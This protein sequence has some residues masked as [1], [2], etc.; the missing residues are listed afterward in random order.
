MTFLTLI[1]FI[2]IGTG[3]TNIVVNASILDKVREAI[4]SR[5]KFMAGLLE[6]MLCTGFWVGVLL[7][8][9]YVG[10]GL[11]AGGALIS[12]T[13]YTFG[14]IMSYAHLKTDVLEAQ[15]EYIDVEED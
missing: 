10:I 14:T 1:L 3:I 7:S 8:I 4:T 13:S 6:C 2:L 12:L 9:N 11:I 5:S 15:I